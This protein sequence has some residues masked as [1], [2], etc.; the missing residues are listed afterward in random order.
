MAY[1]TASR[2]VGLLRAG[3]ALY[4]SGRESQGVGLVVRSLLKK[5]ARK[6]ELWT[7][8]TSKQK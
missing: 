6:I 5:K 4:R 3:L 7:K 8:L 2:R 1:F